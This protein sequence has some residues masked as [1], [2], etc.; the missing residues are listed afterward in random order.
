MADIMDL[1]GLD[2][3]SSQAFDNAEAGVTANLS[4]NAAIADTT[5]P[6]SRGVTKATLGSIIPMTA[7]ILDMVGASET[8]NNVMTGLGMKTG[9]DA[10]G[11]VDIQGDDIS[12][13]TRY[14][15][16]G[17]PISIGVRAGLGALSRGATSLVAKKS[18]TRKIGEEGIDMGV[19]NL[20]YT[21]GDITTAKIGKDGFET[22]VATDKFMETYGMNLAFDAVAQ[23]AMS[24]AIGATV[25]GKNKYKV[26]KSI[27]GKEHLEYNLDDDA[28]AVINSDIT[29]RTKD[30]KFNPHTKPDNVKKLDVQVGE[31]EAGV[32][33]SKD[34]EGTV[35]VDGEFYR[36]ND[37]NELVKGKLEDGLIVF[38]EESIQSDGGFMT[39]NSYN[40]LSGNSFTNAS[41]LTNKKNMPYAIKDKSGKFKVVSEAQGILNGDDFSGKKIINTK[42]SQIDNN[43]YGLKYGSDQIVRGVDT[44]A[45]KIL[46]AFGKEDQ[47]TLNKNVRNFSD[48]IN[49]FELD[50]DGNPQFKTDSKTAK[51]MDRRINENHMA[52]YMEDDAN[53]NLVKAA[54]AKQYSDAETVT[55]PSGNTN[56][57]TNAQILTSSGYNADALQGS[58]MGNLKTFVDEADGTFSSKLDIAVKG[59]SQTDT[60]MHLPEAVKGIY[61]TTEP[62][63]DGK[64]KVYG[65]KDELKKAIDVAYAIKL[66]T[67]E[68]VDGLYENKSMNNEV[69]KSAFDLLGITDPTIDPIKNDL[70]RALDEAQSSDLPSTNPGLTIQD[71]KVFRGTELNEALTKQ[72]QEF[73]E[74]AK[75]RQDFVQKVLTNGSSKTTRGIVLTG[76]PG[77]IRDKYSL[78]KSGDTSLHN[79]ASVMRNTTYYFTDESQSLLDQYVAIADA[80]GGT[81]TTFTE[82]DVYIADLTDAV[83][84]PEGMTVAQTIRSKNFSATAK[85]NLRKK[86]NE[87]KSEVRELNDARK[88]Y[89]EDLGIHFDVEVDSNTRVRYS[90]SANPQSSKIARTLLTTGDSPIA[91]NDVNGAIDANVELAKRSMLANVGIKVEGIHNVADIDGLWNKLTSAVLDSNGNIKKSLYKMYKDKNGEIQSAGVIDIA[92]VKSYFAKDGI[93]DVETIITLNSFKDIKNINAALTTH[94][95]DAVPMFAEVDSKMSGTAIM[96]GSLGYKDS[97]IGIGGKIDTTL[98]DMYTD[99]ALSMGISRSDA[100]PGFMSDNYG[101]SAFAAAKAISAAMFKDLLQTGNINPKVAGSVKYFKETNEFLF[102]NIRDKQKYINELKTAKDLM[103]KGELTQE[104]AAAQLS[105]NKDTYMR[106]QSLIEKE[107]SGKYAGIDTLTLASAFEDLGNNKVLTKGQQE[108]VINLFAK[109]IENDLSAAL[110]KNFIDAGFND[111]LQLRKDI[112]KVVNQVQQM[113]Y[114]KYLDNNIDVDKATTMIKENMKALRK[115]VTDATVNDILINAT[116]FNNRFSIRSLME[117]MITRGYIGKDMNSVPMFKDL[118]PK[119]DIGDGKLVPLITMEGYAAYSST[120]SF[121]APTTIG[122]FQPI[123]TISQDAFIMGNSIKD[124]VTN[125]SDAFVAGKSMNEVVGKANSEFGRIIRDNNPYEMFGDLHA[126]ELEKVQHLINNKEISSI[127][128]E[129][130]AQQEILSK[131]GIPKGDYLDMVISE[132]KAKNIGDYENVSSVRESMRT[133]KDTV[134]ARKDANFTSDMEIN[135]YSNGADVQ[136]SILGDGVAIARATDPIADYNA[137]KPYTQTLSSMKSID[138]DG[139]APVS[140]IYDSSTGK[141]IANDNITVSFGKASDRSFQTVDTTTGNILRNV[142]LTFDKPTFKAL[143]TLVHELAHTSTERNRTYVDVLQNELVELVQNG[144]F[145]DV[146]GNPV[147]VLLDPESIS[148]GEPLSQIMHTLYTNELL[149]DN[150]VAFAKAFGEKDLAKYLKPLV[151]DGA[152]IYKAKDLNNYFTNTNKAD[153][154]SLVR[155]LSNSINGSLNGNVDIKSFFNGMSK[156]DFNP[157]VKGATKSVIASRALLAKVNAKVGTL[158]VSDLFQLD[159]TKEAVETVL[160]LKQGSDN[161]LQNMISNFMEQIDPLVKFEDIQDFDSNVGKMALQGV[162]KFLK[163]FEAANSSNDFV[164]AVTKAMEQERTKIK[165]VFKNSNKFDSFLKE[166]KSMAAGKDS[167]PRKLANKYLNDLYPVSKDKVDANMAALTD[168]IIR[169]AANTRINKYKKSIDRVWSD[170]TEI[171]AKNNT[172]TL[173]TMLETDYNNK[174]TLFNTNAAYDLNA[175]NMRGFAVKKSEF[176]GKD[177]NIIGSGMTDSG[178]QYVVVSKNDKSYIVGK[179]YSQLMDPTVNDIALGIYKIDTKDGFVTVNPQNANTKNKYVDTSISS[180]LSRNLYAKQYNDIAS[181]TSF[182]QFEILKNAGVIVTK[183]QYNNLD[184]IAKEDFARNKSNKN[185]PSNPLDNSFGKHYYSKKWAKYFEG[186]SGFDFGKKNM[187]KMFGDQFGGFISSTVK[188]VL[189]LTSALKGPILVYRPA[190]Y[191][192]SAVS[193]MMVYAI[194]SDDPFSAKQRYAQVKTNLDSYKKLL[195]KS[196]DI[197]STPEARK[198]AEKELKAHDYYTAFKHGVA[199]TI[200]SDAFNTASYQENI[201]YTGIKN[202]TKDEVMAN[203]MKT[204]LADPSTK[205]GSKLGELFDNTEVMPKLMMYE[206]NRAKLGNQGAIQQ[207]LLAFPTY[208]NLP[209]ILNAIDQI[210]PFTKYMANYPKMAM[211]AFGNNKLKLSATMAMFFGGVRSSYGEEVDGDENWWYDNNFID[212]GI[213]YKNWESLNPYWIPTKGIDSGLSIIDFTFIPSVVGT[214]SDPVRTLT[215]YTPG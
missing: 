64:V 89:S 214:F 96:L 150:Q 203:T 161:A 51:D 149:M 146:D 191:I 179:Q 167:T 86:I 78:L 185:T 6:F 17:A 63:K 171:D 138:Y 142:E 182:R 33:A 106:L 181:E 8:S 143:K 3:Q 82:S 166:I 67:K 101:S 45:V 139:A 164:N 50:K 102:K 77:G 44:E 69:V 144:R 201:I 112:P 73:G 36:V 60:G 41:E 172:V 92:K 206:A 35:E 95:T 136:Q 79:T 108:A 97:R 193:N 39:L 54:G 4:S 49:F 85:E 200:R 123:F 119:V 80:P 186:S 107:S 24:S 70:I 61:K 155:K 11:Q 156:Q 160:A 48:L 58:E 56:K 59:F 21:T 152:T 137:A 113:F 47:A 117:S 93:F 163:E 190:S 32:L 13:L 187:D 83:T 134:N 210:S 173:L 84:P 2:L 71:G 169:E 104:Q 87:F 188:L 194:N 202:V 38:P 7:G 168:F 135:N 129:V 154:A 66:L 140:R 28:L 99:I 177:K 151:I 132:N 34:F 20:A 215:P 5:S 100:K 26:K 158:G 208:N 127:V 16:P 170:Y 23:T 110:D 198:L 141:P 43:M 178:E 62:D 29:S 109:T 22:K 211:Y 14:V 25:Y 174:A 189:G 52:T 118:I 199:S 12:N 9:I 176:T 74:S 72:M 128:S 116:K 57:N 65:I 212:V 126:Q 213:G 195:A 46:K 131:G 105:L 204:F 192:N 157:T 68:D 180:M 115:P 111:V 197:S 205:F 88:G 162:G 1:P 91:L 209:S 184:P 183:E 18:L 37:K 90:D 98:Q 30:G 130:M 133:G 159:A 124:G 76:E 10:Q 103:E 19:Q 148:N 165:S 207:V 153:M 196:I 145:T 55:T 114:Y 121:S 40:G 15:L 125:I 27:E 94:S 53:F 75:E 120:A 81:Y 147:G 31:T 122:V 175:N 42:D